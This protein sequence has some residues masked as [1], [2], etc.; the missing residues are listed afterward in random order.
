MVGIINLENAHLR[1][2]VSPQ[3]GTILSLDSLSC[4]LPVLRSGEGRSPG[5]CGL[6]PMLPVANRVAG[7]AFRLQ[8]REVQLPSS[9]ADS[10][11]F[12]HGD[13]WLTRWDI[14]ERAE[15]YCLLQMRQRHP[16]GFDYCAEL[17]YALRGSTLEITLNLT[18][19]GDDPML[20]GGGIHPFFA[21]TP[22]SQIDF[23]AS[24]YWPEGEQ[25]LPCDWTDI[26]PPEADFHFPQFGK[27]EWLNVGYS[28][29]SG[30]ARLRHPTMTVTLSAPTPWLMLF[31]MAGEPFVC[32]EPQSHPVNAHH[33]PG[34]PGLVMLA[35]G[36]RWRFTTRIM[37]NH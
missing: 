35:K 33:M 10:H 19:L 9:L 1:M 7:N 31:R 23:S 29:W 18:H 2:R 36:E 16:C 11:F 27:D 15:D 17:R 21:L 22:Q 13:G 30:V 20:Y 8:G 14:L 34:Q 3:G 24:G 25:H 26:L 37:V 4:G 32:L 28:G 12:L 6:F 5:D